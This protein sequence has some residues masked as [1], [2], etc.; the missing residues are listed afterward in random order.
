MSVSVPNGALIAVAASYDA[1]VAITAISNASPAV[2]T[3]AGHTFVAG[4]FVEITSGWSRLTSKIVRVLSVVASTSFT[5][6]DYDTTDTGTYPTGGGAGS[7]RAVDSWTQLSQI[8]T[9]AT[10]GGDQQFATYQFLESDIELQIPTIKS[11]QGFTLT[12]ADDASQP[13]FQLAQVANNDRDPRAVRVTLPS[14]SI[15]L[16]NAYVSLNPTPTLTVNQVMACQ[17]T[18]SFLAEPVRYTS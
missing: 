16:Y 1:P 6:E 11:A 18:L 2:A 10:S 13:G 9:S 17:V 5:I 8:L 14:G 15:I 4:D 7:A 3:A 12:V